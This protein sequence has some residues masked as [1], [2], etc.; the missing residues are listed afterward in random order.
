MQV[1]RRLFILIALVGAVVVAS[2]VALIVLQQGSTAEDRG[3]RTVVASTGL[4]GEVVYKL[5]G[6]KVSVKVLLP[7]GAEVHEWEPSASDVA[8]IGRAVLVVYTSDSLESYMRK[9]IMASGS[10]AVVVKIEDAPG[11]KLIPL[12][13]DDHHEDHQ[14]GDVDPHIWISLENYIAFVRHLSQKLA[15][16]FPEL[17]DQIAENERAITGR[18]ES[19]LNEYRERLSPYRGRPFLTE[20]LAFRYLAKEF[21]LKNIAI[22][23]VEEQEPD[24][25]R[26]VELRNLVISYRIRA[27]YVDDP[28]AASKTVQSFARDLGLKMLKLDTMEAMTLEE[29]LAGKGYLERMRQNLEALMEE[30]RD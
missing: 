2:A 1:S 10:R 16:V 20:H 15:A 24:P 26:L 23:G 4:I 9:A 8:A 6:G 12:D 28:S 17:R 27:I 3:A 5:T 25:Q 19:L 18:A 21:G 14:H 11:V 22:K 30:F 29:A 7:P 13:E